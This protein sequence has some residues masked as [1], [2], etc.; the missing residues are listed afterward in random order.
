MLS[1]GVS[2]HVFLPRAGALRERP[3]AGSPGAGMPCAIAIGWVLLCSLAP[4]QQQVF[5][6]RQAGQA[7]LA[8]VQLGPVQHSENLYIFLLIF[9]SLKWSISDMKEKTSR[10]RRCL[11]FEGG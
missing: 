9:L 1:A 11:S 10:E 2:R 8:G 4:G 6:V 3:A 7:P 5:A